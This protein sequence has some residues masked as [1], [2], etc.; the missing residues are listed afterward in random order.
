MAGVSW[1]EAFA[2]R[3]EHWSA[4]MTADIAFYVALARQNGSGPR[5]G[6][7]MALER[8]WQPGYPGETLWDRASSYPRSR[9]LSRCREVS[10]GT[11]T[12]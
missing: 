7:T 8:G 11:L 12:R 10:T 4:E 3:Y 6:P 9:P 2:D 5:A 1:D